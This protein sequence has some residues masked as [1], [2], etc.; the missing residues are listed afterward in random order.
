MVENIKS[1]K[2]DFFKAHV[3]LL[4][5]YQCFKLLISPLNNLMEIIFNYQKSV[6]N[7][8]CLI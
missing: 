5:H 2:A 7:E 6:L 1:I 3:I 8:I 4:H